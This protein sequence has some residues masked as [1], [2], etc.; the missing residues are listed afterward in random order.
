MER[1][2]VALVQD[3]RRLEGDVAN[4]SVERQKL[5]KEKQELAKRETA[6]ASSRDTQTQISGAPQALSSQRLGFQVASLSDDLRV[7]W[8]I[9]PTV[10]GVVVINSD[11]K[12]ASYQRGIRPG[13]IILQV[14]STVILSQQQ[15]ISAMDAAIQSDIE[16][17]WVLVKFG[18]QSPV[19]RSIALR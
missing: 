15:F 14:A 10:T 8:G 19:W 3:R 13:V 2:R 1:D 9:A 7:R 11:I 17:V 18:P 12:S 4:I 16:S 6:S 5:E